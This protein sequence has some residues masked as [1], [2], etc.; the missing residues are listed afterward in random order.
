MMNKDKKRRIFYC[1]MIE[2]EQDFFPKSFSN[3]QMRKATD[4]H[5]IGVQLAKE[6][7]RIIRQ[8]VAEGALSMKR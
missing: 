7:F 2:F 1:S 6:S 4:S 8:E 3:E 5:T